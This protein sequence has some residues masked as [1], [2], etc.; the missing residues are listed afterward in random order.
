MRG[1]ILAVWIGMAL[2][3]AGTVEAAGKRAAVHVAGTV[4][5]NEASPEQLDL[6]PGVGAKAAKGIVDYR[7]Q[8]P[9]SRAE[10]LV[11][12][13]GFG[14]KRFERLKA[15]LSVKGPSTLKRVSAAGKEVSG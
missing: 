8:H 15:F 4:N 6:L 9:F 14:K 7:K 5:L 12:V 3:A 1:S 11:K 10:E 2:L 13:K